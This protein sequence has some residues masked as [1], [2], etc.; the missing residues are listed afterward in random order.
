MKQRFNKWLSSWKTFQL[1]PESHSEDVYW[2]NFLWPPYAQTLLLC[3]PAGCWKCSRFW[4]FMSLS[5]H[6]REATST[7]YKHCM[8]LFLPSVWR[9]PQTSWFAALVTPE[10]FHV[11]L[12]TA[13][14]NRVWVITWHWLELSECPCRVFPKLCCEEN[15]DVRV[16]KSHWKTLVFT[17]VLKAAC[18]EINSSS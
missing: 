18:L 2:L 15:H 17:F 6:H 14:C 3:F 7:L 13:G 16:S 1:H 8:I 11:Q 9:L 12:Q 4:S 10:R 5:L